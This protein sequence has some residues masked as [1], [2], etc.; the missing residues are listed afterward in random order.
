MHYHCRKQ[1][2]ITGAGVTCNDVLIDLESYN[3]S[4]CYMKN[5]F[6]FTIPFIHKCDIN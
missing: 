2:Y 3:T 6:Y 5:T 1:T 4:K